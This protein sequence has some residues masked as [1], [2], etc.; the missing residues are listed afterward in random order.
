ML[1]HIA[2][3]P[4]Q[5]DN[6][7]PSLRLASRGNGQRWK[8]F[9][10]L[11]LCL[12]SGLGLRRG[13]TTSILLIFREVDLAFPTW[14]PDVRRLEGGEDPWIFLEWFNC[15]AAPQL[16]RVQCPKISTTT[17]KNETW[18]GKLCFWCVNL[19]SN[20]ALKADLSV[21][22]TG[23]NSM[24]QTDCPVCGLSK[25][26]ASPWGSSPSLFISTSTEDKQGRRKGEEAQTSQ[27]FSLL[28]VLVDLVGE[29]LLLAKMRHWDY[30]WFSI[31]HALPS[32]NYHIQSN[33]PNFIVLAQFT[34]EQKHNAQILEFLQR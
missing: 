29:E 26:S 34:N 12:V 15:F 16:N 18:K 20:N 17:I 23:V 33:Q 19:A 7:S 22:S 31:F 24:I 13:R 21:L 5:T 9:G 14:Y 32:P 3:A 6:T 11:F 8:Y 28:A 25:P 10:H 30:L 2:V 1:L 27:F 4:S